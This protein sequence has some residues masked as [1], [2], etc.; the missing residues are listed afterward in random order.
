M[1][2]LFVL[3]AIGA[4]FASCQT[5]TSYKFET[6]EITGICVPMKGQTATP[7]DYKKN[8][9]V[10]IAQIFR[11]KSR[12]HNGADTLSGSDF[13]IVQSPQVNHPLV[14]QVFKAKIVKEIT[15]WSVL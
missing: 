5:R 3:F 15:A 14:H 6:G 9:S 1:K 4:L 13:F 8:E 11:Y 2:K 7:C 10:Y 12:L